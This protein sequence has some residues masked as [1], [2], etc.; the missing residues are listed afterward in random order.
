MKSK[1]LDT[2]W[3]PQLLTD[4]VPLSF[5]VKSLFF[6]KSKKCFWDPGG[7]V[8]QHPLK[9]TT[10]TYLG[11]SDGWDMS[12]CTREDLTWNAT[13]LKYAKHQPILGIPSF[14][15]FL[16]WEARSHPP[17]SSGFAN[18]MLQLRVLAKHTFLQLEKQVMSEETC[19]LHMVAFLTLNSSMPGHIESPFRNFWRSILPPWMWVLWEK[20]PEPEIAH[21]LRVWGKTRLCSSQVL[22]WGNANTL[23]LL[24][25]SVG[26]CWKP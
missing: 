4:S 17:H 7:Y 9:S 5:P 11:Y 13:I 19:H 12:S 24:V 15:F 1:D 26:L 6:L 21:K 3:C 20:A 2:G 8:S 25:E 22:H 23:L 16:P 14:N 18:L 10:T